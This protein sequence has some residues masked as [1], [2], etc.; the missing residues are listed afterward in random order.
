MNVKIGIEM[1]NGTDCGITRYTNQINQQVISDLNFKLSPAGFKIKSFRVITNV[2]FYSFAFWYLHE[3][4]GD[5]LLKMLS[6]NQ[7]RVSL[8]GESRF[9]QPRAIKA[10]SNLTETLGSVVLVELI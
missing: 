7:K 3:P 8:W 2:Y 10:E 5:P 9:G 4:F 1:E 6:D